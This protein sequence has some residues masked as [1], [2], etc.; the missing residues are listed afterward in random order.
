MRG[1]PV[2]LRAMGASGALLLLTGCWSSLDFKNAAIVMGTGFDSD[3]QGYRISVEMLIP[4]AEQSG[5]QSNPVAQ[6][7]V[8]ERAD[9]N[10]HGFARHFIRDSKRKLVFTHNRVWIVKDTLAKE[11]LLRILD[12]LERGEML[13]MHSYLFITPENPTEILKTHPLFKTQTSIELSLGMKEVK[14]VSDYATP[15]VRE[16]MRMLSEPPYTAFLP[17][18]HIRQNTNKPIP[19]VGETAIIKGDHMIG[20]LNRNET[21]GLLWLRGSVKGT[22]ISAGGIA[23][24]PV[25]I[26]AHGLDTK[27]KPVLQDGKLSVNVKVSLR[28]AVAEVAPEVRVNEDF[29]KELEQQVSDKVAAQIRETLQTL[30]GTFQTDI[31]GIG[32]EVYRRYPQEWHRLEKNWD[33]LFAAAKVHVDVKAEIYHQGLVDHTLGADRARPKFNPYRPGEWKER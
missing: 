13:R 11:N 8:L 25:Q 33:E 12:I 14:F 1:F 15:N 17:V 21:M 19:E 18:L 10:L 4:G 24:H 5:S 7:L 29:I 30:Q 22:T 9:Q 31:T 6:S 32:L 26:E 27:I 2:W 3:P 23:D 28:G 16:F 20:E